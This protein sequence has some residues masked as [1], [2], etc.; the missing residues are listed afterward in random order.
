[1]RVFPKSLI[2]RTALF[3]TLLLIAN[4][5]LW[6]AVVRPIVFNR[7]VQAYQVY[8]P[9]GVLRLYVEL[10][11]G[12]FALLTSTLGVYVIFFW[13]RRQL[14]S[15]I[16]AARDLG[17][18]RTPAPLA[19]TGPVEIRELSRGFNQLAR[20]LDALEADRRLMLAGISHDLSTPL[21]RMRLALEL[22]QL[23][24]D[25]SQAAG[26]LE[27]LEDMN[28]ILKQFADYARSGQEEAPVSG[29]FNRVVAD[30]CRR[31]RATGIAVST[32]LAEMPEFTFRPLA[33][34]RLVSN[35]L[36]N[37][38]R[39]GVRDIRVT[40]RRADGSVALKVLDRGPGIRSADPNALIKP[41]AREDPARGAQLGAG[42]GLSIVERIARIHG[43]DLHLR[44]RVGGG[45]EATVT[46]PAVWLPHGT[47]TGVEPSS[48]LV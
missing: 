9:A 44:N 14:Q 5:F 45:L 8:H 30:L 19:E 39:Y 31:Y 35:L 12:L 25:P 11:W 17:N 27:D 23:K 22:L 18:G 28:G 48:K 46:L 41:F 16:R 4:Q 34:R 36:D 37:A 1:M 38:V 10:E 40:T 33:I 2:G 32:D 26:M 20:N 47:G 15:V 7:Y 42:L 43:G 21:T 29:D 13:M 6:I 3:V 24:A